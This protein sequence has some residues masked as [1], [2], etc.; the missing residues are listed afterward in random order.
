[1]LNFVFSAGSKSASFNHHN[2]TIFDYFDTGMPEH[3]LEFPVFGTWI[4]YYP[5]RIQF[6]DI[7]IKGIL[8]T[9][10]K[11]KGDCVDVLKFWKS[12][13]NNGFIN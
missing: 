5:F 7:I 1:M 4:E 10:T 2:R 13:L 9:R 12:C 11:V 8:I 6:H 3:N